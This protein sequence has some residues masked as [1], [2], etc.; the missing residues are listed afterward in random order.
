LT[1]FLD[2][3]LT[4]ERIDAPYMVIGAFAAVL[5]GSTRTTYDIDIVVD[6]QQQHVQALADAYP[7][8]RYYADP[9]QMHSSIATGMPF[10]IIDSAR[11][12]KADLSPLTRDS[13]YRFAFGRRIRQRIEWEGGEPFD[14][15]CARPDDVIFGK[16]LAW[17]EGRSLKHRSDIYDMLAFHYLAADPALAPSFDEAYLDVQAI[18]LGPEVAEF[19]RAIK[20]A[21]RA[22]ASRSEG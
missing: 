3:L 1:L 11:G 12:E 19:W 22:E 16:L 4:L 13:R 21:A 15:W 9:V 20:A 10:N 2:I 8:P 7:S 14:A 6:L 17:R 18:A 5:Y